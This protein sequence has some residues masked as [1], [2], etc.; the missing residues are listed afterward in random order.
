MALPEP[1]PNTNAARTPGMPMVVGFIYWFYAIAPRN[2]LDIWKNYLKANL[3]FFS[4]PMLYKTLFQPWH[5]DTESYGRGFDI[6][7][8][9]N[10]LGLNIASR[11]IGFIIRGFM[12]IFALIVELVIILVGATFFVFWLA[13]PFIIFFVFMGSMGLLFNI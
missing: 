7:K 4:V 8:F 13:L 12:I 11:A 1:P 9:L 6:E 3:H 5:R 10:T 2:I